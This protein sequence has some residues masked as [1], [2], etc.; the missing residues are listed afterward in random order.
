LEHVRGLFAASGYDR[1]TI[2]AAAA[3]GAD[4]ALVMHYFGSKEKLF[5]RAIEPGARPSRRRGRLAG[6]VEGVVL[7][8]SV[9]LKSS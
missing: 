5:A 8:A 1:T 3:A 9:R 6:A 4:P 7:K 2:R